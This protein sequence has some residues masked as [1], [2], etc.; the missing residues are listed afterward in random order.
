VYQV[1][2]SYSAE[3]TPNAISPTWPEHAHEVWD[4]TLTETI[5]VTVA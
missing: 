4:L 2:C 5:D 1:R 3:V